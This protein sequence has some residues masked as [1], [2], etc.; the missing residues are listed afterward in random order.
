M[1]ADLVARAHGGHLRLPD[2]ADAGSGFSAE[3]V[4]AAETRAD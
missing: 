2:A 4:L 3:L 1:L